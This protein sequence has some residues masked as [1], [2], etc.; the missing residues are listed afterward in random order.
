MYPTV[1]LS[2][3]PMLL[4]CHALGS[5]PH[6]ASLFPS[7]QLH[8]PVRTG[9]CVRTGLN[10]HVPVA[11]EG[12]PYRRPRKRASFAWRSVPQ[13]EADAAYRRTTLSF[14]HTLASLGP[15]SVRLRAGAAK[16]PWVLPSHLV[17]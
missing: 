9:T 4:R 3:A 10:H 14:L 17:S 2:L 16:G 7:R 13:P 8:V 11:V 5:S 6:T 12:Q 1:G 15:P